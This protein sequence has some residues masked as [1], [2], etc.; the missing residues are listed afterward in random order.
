[1]KAQTK[2]VLARTERTLK[3]A[4][5]DWSHVVDGVVYLTDMSK[6]QDMN[7][8]YREIFSQGFPRARDG[9]HRP[10]GRR[11]PASRSCSRR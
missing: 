9:R 11:R 3:A 8:A 1:M 6:F 10:D 5:Y 4:G 2:E 7:A